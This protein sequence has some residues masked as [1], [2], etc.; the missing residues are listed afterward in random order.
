MA[1]V[2]RRAP[3]RFDR[4]RRRL[5]GLA[6]LCALPLVALAARSPADAAMP[7]FR[8]VAHPGHPE[9]SVERAFLAD[10]FLKK[11]TRWN[12]GETGRPADLRP[13][14]GARRRFTEVVL[15][16]SFG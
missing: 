7:E 14:A 6:L 1:E 10:A 12:S 9:G 8:V 15:K 16:R 4:S 13:N 11:V 3:A 2:V 5:L